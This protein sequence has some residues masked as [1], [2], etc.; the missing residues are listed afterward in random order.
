MAQLAQGEDSCAFWGLA[1][2]YTAVNTAA[3]HEACALAV[4]ATQ[5]C[6]TQQHAAQT[7]R[8]YACG[9]AQLTWRARA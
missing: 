1:G 5:I 6:I 9:V 3:R 8:A 2:P 4:C 7:V